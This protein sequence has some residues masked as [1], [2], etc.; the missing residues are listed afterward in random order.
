MQDL[1]TGRAEGTWKATFLMSPGLAARAAQAS[2]NAGSHGTAN[3]AGN[4][5]QHKY[6][7]YTG[8]IQ[9]LY[10]YYTSIIQVLYRSYTE[11][12]QVLYGSYIGII[13]VLY[14]FY[15]GISQVLYRKTHKLNYI[16]KEEKNSS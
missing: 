13:Q 12:I 11:L 14:R 1:P 7:C 16:K 8:T 6:R 9:V 4:T 10:R 3:Q 2:C 15:T 5:T